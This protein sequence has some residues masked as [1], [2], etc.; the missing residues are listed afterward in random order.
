MAST[1]TTQSRSSLRDRRPAVPLLLSSFPLP[2][3]HIPSNAPL[4]PS[5]SLT[6]P[7]SPPSIH[8]NPPPSLPPASP[9]P[10]IPGPSLVS[11]H[12]TLAIMSAARSR[13]TSK[14][15]LNSISS[16]SRRSS[17][18]SSASI[19]LPSLSPSTSLTP[20]GD[21]TRS[22]RSYPSNGSLAAPACWRGVIAGVD[23][24][25]VLESRICEE[26]PADLTR[27]SLDEICDPEFSDDE[28]GLARIGV[29]ALMDHSEHNRSS[30]YG[31]SSRRRHGHH[32]NDSISSIDMRDLPPLNERDDETAIPLPETFPSP[33]KKRLDKE[34]PPLPAE[35]PAPRR[36]GAES[37]DIQTILAKTPRPRRKSSGCASRSVSRSRARSLRRHVSDG[38][39]LIS[40]KSRR[41]PEGMRG[42]PSLPVR[43]DFDTPGD[44]S[45]IEDYGAPLDA[46]GTP[47]DLVDVEE[48]EVLDR[49]LDGEGSDSDSDLDIHTP[50]PY[51]SL[52]F[53]VRSQIDVAHHPAAISCCEMA[54]CPRTLSFCRKRKRLT[55]VPEAT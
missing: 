43:L 4:V 21:S 22:L 17:T 24:S 14:M 54:Y 9:L 8:A 46:T 29:S 48:E 53:R 30:L 33:K 42:R 18:A 40:S 28:K 51:V 23:K 2:P 16:Y 31:H 41:Q 44:D 32:A 7:H 55:I 39:T 27:M 38:T 26:D 25:P 13:R 15:S 34:L 5:P 45:F 47:M 20:G 37:P 36:A 11:Q 49:A 1:L 3:S 10:P 6:F 19:S 35:V 52:V 50:L 12:E